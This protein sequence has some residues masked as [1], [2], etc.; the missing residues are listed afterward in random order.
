M[1]HERKNRARMGSQKN[2]RIVRQPFDGQVQVM[3][4][5]GSQ[6]LVTA[7]PTGWDHGIH[8]TR[9]AK[10]GV[11]IVYRSNVQQHPIMTLDEDGKC[12]PTGKSEYV[13]VHE[14]HEV[15]S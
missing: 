9:H 15:G 14:T 5:S 13:I 2:P 6:C 3:S 7:T 1:K 8:L 10:D 4:R 12:V 11:I